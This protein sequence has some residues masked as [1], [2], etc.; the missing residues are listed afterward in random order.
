MPYDDPDPV[1]PQELV[2]VE[3]PGDP[4]VTRHMAA[5]FA[6]EFAQLGYT[7]REILGLFRTP[8]YAAVH[9][10]WQLLG[11]EEI[12]SIVAESVGVWRRVRPTTIDRPDAADAKPLRQG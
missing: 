10:T 12:A 6:D 8:F 7:D 1:D 11:E 4:E 5:A 2:G 3:M 9:R